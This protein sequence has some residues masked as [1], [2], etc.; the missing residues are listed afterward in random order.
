MW[1]NLDWN[2]EINTLL[3]LP[4]E[5]APRGTRASDGSQDEAID[6]WARRRQQFRDGKRCSSAG[7]SSFASNITEG[8]SE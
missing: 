6:Q 3:K 4:Q 5:L 1:F 7:G 8:S 2:L